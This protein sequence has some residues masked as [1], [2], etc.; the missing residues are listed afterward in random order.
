MYFR[1][2][3]NVFGGHSFS[4]SNT[5]THWCYLSDATLQDKKSNRKE[6]TNNWANTFLTK[7]DRN[8]YVN[9]KH[10]FCSSSYTL[11]PSVF[12]PPSASIST[13]LSFWGRDPHFQSWGVCVLYHPSCIVPTDLN[14]MPWQHQQTPWRIP[15]TPDQSCIPPLWR[16]NTHSLLVIWIDHLPDSVT[17]SLD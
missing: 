15:W 8:T 16:S 14:P 5:I 9:Y 4:T 10:H 1:E 13:E 3:D 6:N 7:Y 11:L 2:G 17:I 12:P